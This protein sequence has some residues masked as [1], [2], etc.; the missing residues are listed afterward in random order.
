MGI[1]YRCMLKS[2]RQAGDV[3]GDM[4]SSAHLDELAAAVSPTDAHELHDWL[5]KGLSRLTLEQ[6]ITLELAYCL[7]HSLEEIAE[8]VGSPVSTVKARMFH[9]RI[10]LGN[11][12]R[13]L[14]GGERSNA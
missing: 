11:L 10:K 9:A 7:G 5:S 8:I 2:M 3:P 1:A 6:R 13:D 12:L 14:D 4:L